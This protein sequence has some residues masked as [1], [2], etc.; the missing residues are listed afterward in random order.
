MLPKL[1]HELRIMGRSGD[2][3]L[4]WDSDDKSQVGKARLAFNEY[5]NKGY[6]MYKT[7]TI[8]GKKVGEPIDEFDP[9]IERM[10]AVPPMQGGDRLPIQSFNA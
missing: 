1:V 9:N 8:G 3:K 10:I 7:E 6:K 2:E 4:T 5:K